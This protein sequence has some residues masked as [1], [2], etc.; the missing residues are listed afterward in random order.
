MSRVMFSA[1]CFRR[2]VRPCPRQQV[3]DV[4]GAVAVS[5]DR[6]YFSG[7][8]MTRHALLEPGTRYVIRCGTKHASGGPF[9]CDRV[10]LS[11]VAL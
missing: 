11:M 7:L 10:S 3:L 1:C 4:S 6:D 2:L 9:R 5:N 8:G